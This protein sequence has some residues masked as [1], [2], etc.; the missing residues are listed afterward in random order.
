MDASAVHASAA[1]AAVTW[2][3]RVATVL[4]WL[5]FVFVTPEIVGG[6]R[7][8]LLSTLCQRIGGRVFTAVFKALVSGFPGT[9]PGT[10]KAPP[11]KGR[12]E[13][14]LTAILGPRRLR[15][16][17]VSAWQTHPPL[18]RWIAIALVPMP[19]LLVVALAVALLCRDGYR[20][21]A[22]LPL[23]VGP[24]CLYRTKRLMRALFEAFKSKTFPASLPLKKVIEVC[25]AT[26]YAWWT[27]VVT[28]NIAYAITW[29]SQRR[30]LR[31]ILFGLGFLF[32]TASKVIQFRYP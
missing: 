4:E 18:R 2:W 25:F 28:W 23:A 24:W 6:R 9:P 14:I 1:L 10:F 15:A 19:L 30:T 7:L 11:K 17:L 5:A 3:H 13:P 20:L 12:L 21:L 29:L 32:F 26:S 16:T 22:L 31:L 27:F 8:S